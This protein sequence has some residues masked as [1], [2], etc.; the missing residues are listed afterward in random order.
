M[1]RPFIYRGAAQRHRGP[2]WPFPVSG[3]SGP[4][5]LL[6][7]SFSNITSIPPGW[8]YTRTGEIKTITGV[9]GS[10][11]IEVTSFASNVMPY[12][13]V[14]SESATGY[15]HEP[16]GNNN[17]LYSE[18]FSNAAWTKTNV[19]DNGAV[20]DP[21]GNSNA[22]S[23]TGGVGGGSVSQTWT[24]TVGL[25]C[26][27]SVHYKADG[28]CTIV[29]SD[30]GGSNST[31]LTS[32]TWD[33]EFCTYTP[34]ATTMTFQITVPE[35]VTIELFGA[36]AEERWNLSTSVS[37]SS[38]MPTAGASATRTE[39]YMYRSNMITNNEIYWD[40]GELEI[41]YHPLPYRQSA[42]GMVWGTPITNDA[43]FCRINTARS[44]I[45]DS[46]G[47]AAASFTHGNIEVDNVTAVIKLAWS[48]ASDIDGTKEARIAKDGV[49]IQSF[50]GGYTTGTT[51]LNVHIG[52]YDL[53]KPANSMAAVYFSLKSW[54]EAQAL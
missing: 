46:T 50:T 39:S 16:N 48:G 35:G 37:M 34:T 5:P 14:S 21:E 10:G 31:N 9:D 4:V 8:T 30:T 17:I 18:D 20:A 52:N 41:S 25:P 53:A 45:Y 12:M 23:F 7:V 38:Y 43:R 42:G 15:L 6:D 54:R 29:A 26:A 1:S 47:A 28:T 2:A 49:E 13:W 3:P 36:Q 51:N 40:K 11:N 22:R 33:R 44:G 24:S 27:H 32:T 19:T